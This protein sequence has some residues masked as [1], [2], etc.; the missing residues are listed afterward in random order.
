MSCFMV[1]YIRALSSAAAYVVLG[2]MGKNY[3]IVEQV[4]LL[5]GPPPHEDSR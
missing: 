3:S 4:A 2:D 1:S 5:L